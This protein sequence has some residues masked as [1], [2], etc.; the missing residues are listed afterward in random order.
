[1]FEGVDREEEEE[2][3]AG[4][5]QGLIQTFDCC[6]SCLPITHTK[7]SHKPPS[8]LSRPL[9]SNF[10]SLAHLGVV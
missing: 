6:G 1:M 10:D 3:M 4:V 9:L 2:E 8:R 7:S 5:L